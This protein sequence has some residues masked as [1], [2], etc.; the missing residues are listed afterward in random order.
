[1]PPSLFRTVRVSDPRFERDGLRIV[2]VKSPSLKRRSDIS[3]YVPE[4]QSPHMPVILL[5]HGVYGSHWSWS[6]GGGAHLTA[7]RLIR[8]GA[9]QP[10]VLAMPSDGLWGDGSGYLSHGDAN[11][12]QWIVDD[13]PAAVAEVVNNVSDQSP[14]FVAGLSMGGFG[15]LRLG[16]VYADRFAGISA[17]SAITNLQQMADF[18]EE[19][20]DAFYADAS[21]FSAAE[22]LIHG[23]TPPLRFDCGLSDPLLEANR[24]LHSQ[25]AH[26]GIPHRYEE[27]EGG[28]EWPY[29][30]SHLKETLL[31]FEKIMEDTPRS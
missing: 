1:M 14:L 6:L 13:V 7:A 19:P 22:A 25:L 23:P 4:E 16:G 28:H 20:L 26:A 9:I 10:V 29:W 12:E 18:I 11:Y 8:E 3:L 27:F 24:T 15:A 31:F 17:H 2:T 21:H 5:L 30:E